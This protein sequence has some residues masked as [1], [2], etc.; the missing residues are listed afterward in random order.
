MARRSELALSHDRSRQ[1]PDLYPLDYRGDG[2]RV[3]APL[4]G[5]RTQPLPPIGRQLVEPGAP[6]VVGKSPFGRD[7]ALT[8]EAMQRLVKGRILDFECASRTLSDERCDSVA[9]RGTGRQA[10]PARGGPAIPE[11]GEGAVLARLLP[12]D[13]VGRR[14]VGRAQTRPTM[15]RHAIRAARTSGIARVT[16]RADAP[17]LRRQKRDGGRRVDDRPA[18]RARPGPD[19][20]ERSRQHRRRRHPRHGRRQRAGRDEPEHRRDLRRRRRAARVTA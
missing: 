2:L 18:P 3:S 16:R 13:G 8:L 11:A 20:A 6:V 4:R 19:P 15:T 17:R 10:P 1:S 9:M 7:Q 5:V 12:L 14:K